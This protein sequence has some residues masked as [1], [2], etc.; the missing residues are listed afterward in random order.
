[1]NERSSRK[2]CKTRNGAKKKKER[3]GFQTGIESFYSGRTLFRIVKIYFRL[4]RKVAL[5]EG[6]KIL[7]LFYLHN[8]NRGQFLLCSMRSS[9]AERALKDKS[10]TKNENQKDDKSTS[11]RCLPIQIKVMSTL[12]R[13]QERGFVY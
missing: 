10:P 5:V 1:M 9:K 13:S 3:G 2:L 7:P 4:D 6:E 12:F 11:G 8:S